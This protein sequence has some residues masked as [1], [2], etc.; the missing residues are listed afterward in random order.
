MTNTIY[1]HREAGD[2]LETDL[3]RGNLFKFYFLIKFVYIHLTL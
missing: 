3:T 2:E 1:F